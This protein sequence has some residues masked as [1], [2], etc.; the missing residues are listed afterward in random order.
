MSGEYYKALTKN[1]EENI[2]E[3]KKE[4]EALLSAR[5]DAVDSGAIEKYSESWWE[6]CRQIDEVTESIQEGETAILDYA[7]SLR[8]VDWKIFD[9]IQDKIANVADEAQFLVDLMENKKLFED[10]GQ[11][12]DE[13]MAT[14]GLHGM[15]YNV[16]MAQADKYA[17]EIQKINKQLANDPYNQDIIDRKQELIEAQQDAILSAE[18]EK[19]AIKDLVEEGI[20]KELDSLKELIDKYND[21]LDSQKDLY[22]YQKKIAEQTKKVAELQ[23]QMSAY[24]GDDS[25]ETKAKI[26]ELKVSLQEA[27]DDLQ[28][29]EYDKYISD[30]QKLLDDLYNEYELILNERLDNIDALLADMIAKIN[31]NSTTISQTITDSADKVGY[32]LS[33]SM[34]TVWNTSTSSITNV[35]TKYGDNFTTALTTTNT[36]L[37]NISTDVAGMVEQLNKVAKTNIKTAGTSIAAKEEAA[38]PKPAPKPATPASQ[39]KAITVGGRINAG[40]ATIYADSYGG[41]GGRQYYGNDPIYTV[42]DEQRGFLLV[43]HHSLSSGYTGWFRKSDVSAYATG[44]KKLGADEMA[45]TQE[46]GGEMIVRPSDGAILTPLAKN[47]SVLSASASKN[48]WNMANSPADFIKDNLSL[49]KFDNSA[50][51]KA[52]TNVEQ[53]FDKIVFSLPNVK[54]YD[55][56]LSQM[57][58]DKNFERLIMSMTIDQ[59]AGK[60][61]LAKGKA[62]R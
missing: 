25:E 27:K 40:G 21:A 8:E 26:Q 52:Q 17:K 59:I 3:L 28:E 35:I 12:T 14:M 45:W 54:N 10:N 15:N 4:K 6:M 46:N 29:T 30:Q 37:N 19:D 16:Y 50:A 62:I 38:K 61:S 36:A 1:E 34:K 55:Q 22:D 13:G 43:R 2:A 11:L 9:I 42:L 60:S 33:E 20:D 23:K 5:D 48:I 58:R 49:D 47:D 53:N 57:Q 56:F 31:E 7:K 39:P 24:S 18:Q 44:K 32:D 51:N 41:G